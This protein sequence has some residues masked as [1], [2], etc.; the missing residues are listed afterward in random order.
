MVNLKCRKCK[1]E[2]KGK[3]FKYIFIEN[4]KPVKRDICEECRKELFEK[5]GET[6]TEKEYYGE[7]EKRRDGL[8]KQW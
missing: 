1:K 4:G 2:T 6:R 3:F 8:Y 5:M 7:Q